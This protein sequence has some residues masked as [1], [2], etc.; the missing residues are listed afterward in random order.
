M[1]MKQNEENEED[2]EKEDF[3]EAMRQNLNGEIEKTGARILQMKIKAPQT[4]EGN[5]FLCGLGVTNLFYRPN[6]T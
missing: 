1:L 2:P 4:K 3:S 6:Q 5:F